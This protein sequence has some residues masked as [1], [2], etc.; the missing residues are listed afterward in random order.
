MASAT[1]TEKGQIVIPARIRERFGL[2]PGTQVEFVDEGGV[3]RLIVRRR[4]APSE[5][6][7]GFGMIKVTRKAGV[8]R[9]L[10]EFDPASLVIK[11]TGRRK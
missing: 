7:A 4:I 10:S 9:R 2:T 1:L 11:G 6:A 3:L 5:P 8:Q